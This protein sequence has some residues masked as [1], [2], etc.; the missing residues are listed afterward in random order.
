ML[1]RII[2]SS[3]ARQR[4]LAA[5]ITEK[6]A[7]LMALTR[8]Y[9]G[10]TI[11]IIAIPAVALTPSGRW[12]RECA[13][14]DSRPPAYYITSPGPGIFPPGSPENSARGTSSSAAGD[15]R[16][17]GGDPVLGRYL[18]YHAAATWHFRAVP[19]RAAVRHSVA[20]GTARCLRACL[21]CVTIVISGMTA[22]PASPPD[23]G[24]HAWHDRGRT[25]EL[26]V[27]VN[28]KAASGARSDTHFDSIQSL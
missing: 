16:R 5:L 3:E 19:R 2:Y 10:K 7:R 26:S 14:A 18:P 22:R 4:P 20:C 13:S 15:L 12:L 25:C 11:R 27:A 28:E 6:T 1:N 24:Y 17:V 23:A 9:H 8:H 21:R